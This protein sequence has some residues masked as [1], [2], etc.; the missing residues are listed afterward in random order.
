M[1]DPSIQPSIDP[2]KIDE[3]AATLGPSGQAIFGLYVAC[4]LKGEHY[5]ECFARLGAPTYAA[6]LREAL[7]EIAE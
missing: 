4:R 1:I 6:M 7:L 3:M 2:S 5:A